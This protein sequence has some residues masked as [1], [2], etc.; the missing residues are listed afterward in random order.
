M[1]TLPMPARHRLARWVAYVSLCAFVLGPSAFAFPPAPY[2]LIFGTARDQ[3]GTPI[4]SAHSMVILETPTGVRISASLVPGQ[5]AGVNYQIKVPMDAGIT[6]D[7]YKTNALTPSA[8][9]KLYVVVGS[10]TNIPLQMIGNYSL[11]GSPGQ[12]TRIDLTLGVDANG[13][14]IPDAWE[15]AFLTAL[16]SGLPLS[17]LNPNLDLAHD[18]R[19]LQQ[20]FLLGSY[21]FD[22]ADP[23]VVSM[24]GFN[25]NSPILKFPTM[26]G[27]SYTVLG[28]SDLKSWM[29][30]SFHLATESA[31]A[32]PH[33]FYYA[34]GI[35]STLQ[36]QVIQP[37]PAPEKL[38]I[39]ILIQ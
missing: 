25:G 35:Q 29:P 7:L 1:S 2:H 34:P 20:E 8:P 39:K 31:G 3:F 36:I 33:S 21:P 14:G 37:Q 12:S 10:V 38:F 23:F 5:A 27:R 30:L 9:F 11:L 16:G 28:S 4:T 18:G 22:P 24:A 13:D 17:A 19:T 32:Q 15:Q 26:T 6:T